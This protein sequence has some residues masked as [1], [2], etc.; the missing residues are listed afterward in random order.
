M[1]S[2]NLDQLAAYHADALPEA[3]RRALAAHLAEC[4]ACRRELAALD[5]VGHALASLPAPALPEDIWPAVAARIN[6]RPHRVARWWQ[7]A[8]GLGLAA[9]VFMGLLTMR[10]APLPTASSAAASYAAD[11]ALLS[12]Q[13]PLADRAGIGVMLASQENTR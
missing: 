4:A 12:A 9:S 3:A 6:A 13:D 11:H 1:H 10:G 2:P 8:V 5:G 7:T